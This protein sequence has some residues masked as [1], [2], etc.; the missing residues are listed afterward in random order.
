MSF[1]GFGA[2]KLP[3][4]GNLSNALRAYIIQVTKNQSTAKINNVK[5]QMNKF[6]LAAKGT[7]TTPSPII[8]IT[9][10]ITNNNDHRTLLSQ[11]NKAGINLNRLIAIKNQLNNRGYNSTNASTNIRTKYTS[12]INRI[13]AVQAL[14]NAGKLNT[15]SSNQ[16]INKAL[17]NLRRHRNKLPSNMKTSFTT[18]INQLARTSLLKHRSLNNTPIPNENLPES[19]V[20][21]ST[22]FKRAKVNGINKNIHSSKTKP[23]LFVKTNN[24]KYYKLNSNN[25]NATSYTIKNRQLY[26]YNTN[27]DNFAMVSP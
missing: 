14:R 5:S 8:P 16:E 22:I 17:N 9:P 19:H 27:N 11:V 23:G 12:L 18:A 2:R 3:S 26:N 13:A 21:N 6:I 10:A 15:K 7:A 20:L 24:G 1:F 4:T 25:R